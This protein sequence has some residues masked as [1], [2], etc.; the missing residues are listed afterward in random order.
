LAIFWK[1]GSAVSINGHRST[2]GGENTLL[3][4]PP[5]TSPGGRWARLTAP[6]VQLKT[7]E[8][9]NRLSAKRIEYAQIFINSEER[10]IHKEFGQLGMYVDCVLPND[11]YFPIRGYVRDWRVFL[12]ILGYSEPLLVAH[13]E[14]HW[15]FSIENWPGTRNGRFSIWLPRPVQDDY[16]SLWLRLK[17]Y[18]DIDFEKMITNNLLARAEHLGWRRQNTKNTVAA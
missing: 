13:A 3:S 9:M 2:D 10:T 6:V 11:P 14:W 16:A 17:P 8:A 15:L 7:E 4:V 12:P 18:A 1:I 5:T